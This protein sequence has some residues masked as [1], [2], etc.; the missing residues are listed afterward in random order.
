MKRTLS[1]F[2]VLLFAL[3]ALAACG[4][5][6]ETTHTAYTPE[7]PTAY[8]G[9]TV[10]AYA[11]KGPTGMS[12][13][14]LMAAGTQT[15]FKYEFT[16]KDKPDLVVPEIVKGNY[17]IAAL[18]TNVAATLY[19]KTKGELQVVAVNTL[20]VLSVLE[21]G[22]S[23]TSFAD[24]D[25]KTVYYFGQAS[26]PQYIIE[27]LLKKNNVSATLIPVADGA[28]LA[29]LMA[30]GTHAVAILPEPNVSVA[31]N[32]ATQS[33]NTALRVA[34]NLT[35]E[36]QKVSGGKA[37]IQGCIVARRAFLDEIGPTGL[38]ALLSELKAS[39]DFVKKDVSVSAPVIVAQGIIPAVPIAQ[40]AI[41][42]LGDSLCFLTGTDM[43]S[44]LEAF[45]TILYTANPS[46]IGGT[47]PNGYFYALGA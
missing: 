1:L 12:L 10:K 6:D 8:V 9:R 41:N 43:K 45:F 33:G 4:Q 32:K 34:L 19:E 30:S 46:S 47:M 15:E 40:R 20:G 23:I 22:N 35:A 39:A 2:L 13:A 29:T 27:H 26:T 36:W 44:Q 18:P 14:S 24:L 11:I 31:L 42:N 5:D 17:D 37:P 21:N 38:A 16:L 3:L 25:G 7:N 28:E